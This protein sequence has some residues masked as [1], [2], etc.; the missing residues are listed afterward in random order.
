MS[1]D[2]ATM[3]TTISSVRLR[4]MF[5]MLNDS[6]PSEREMMTTILPATDNA[7]CEVSAWPLS[8]R[9]FLAASVLA[10]ASTPSLV[11]GGL[12][13]LYWRFLTLGEARMLT[14]LC[15]VIIPPDQDAGAAQAGVVQ[16]IDRQLV[17][18]HRG[19]Q[20]LYRQGLAALATS[21]QLLF[22]KP[23]IDLA[24]DQ[25]VSLVARWE[26]DE[27]PKEAW[28]AVKPREFFDR[29]VEHVMQGFFGSPRHGGNRDAVS[30]RML[31]VPQPPVRSR[32][33]ESQRRSQP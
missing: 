21:S 17:G 26:K 15:D 25:I 14:V 13:Q 5:S 12:E 28:K 29:F 10:A 2:A 19:S 9:R 23:L 31:G 11:H 16:F 4:C 20:S 18:Y 24:P 30:W 32:R 1:G 8:R 3:T 27:L 22:H 33:P 7:I 6:N